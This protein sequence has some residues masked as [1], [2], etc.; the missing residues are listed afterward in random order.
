MRPAY[1]KIA[2]SESFPLLLE[3]D[4]VAFRVVSALR[5]TLAEERKGQ[6]SVQT[7]GST[8]ASGSNPFESGA[9]RDRA[10]LPIAGV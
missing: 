6:R 5:C 8:S 10:D 9:R 1:L 7:L 4:R 3:E 2:S